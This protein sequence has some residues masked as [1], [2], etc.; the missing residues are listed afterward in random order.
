MPDGMASRLTATALLFLF[1]FDGWYDC[2]PAM[3]ASG[4]R[5]DAR[6]SSSA[7]SAYDPGAS[8]MAPRLNV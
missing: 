8:V 7:Q 2:M 3:R 4:A 5:I 1:N 6:D